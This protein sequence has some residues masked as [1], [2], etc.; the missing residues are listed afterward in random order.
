MR[1]SYRSSGAHRRAIT[2]FERSLSRP[3]AH[4][5]RADDES[6]L[7][8]VVQQGIYN[9][10]SSIEALELAPFTASRNDCYWRRSSGFWSL[11]ERQLCRAA[12]IF[13]AAKRGKIASFRRKEVAASDRRNP[14]RVRPNQRSFFTPSAIA[15][16]PIRQRKCAQF[17]RWRTFRRAVSRTLAERTRH[18]S[19]EWRVRSA[20]HRQ[21]D[22]RRLW[23]RGVS[24]FGDHENS[25]F[26]MIGVFAGMERAGLWKLR[27]QL[28]QTCDVN[29]SSTERVIASDRN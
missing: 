23:G 3:G 10:S 19:R 2:F 14:A 6:N 11:K 13:R 29:W 27:G 24:S 17:H 28:F 26:Q 12:V 16:L 18:I 5:S 4:T 20:C 15:R 8:M 9:A 25:M 1:S 22:H 21:R 7:H